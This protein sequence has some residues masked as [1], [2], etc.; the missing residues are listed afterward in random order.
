[1]IFYII[2]YH[3]VLF[4]TKTRNFRLRDSVIESQTLR[5]TP[6]WIVTSQK[7]NVSHTVGTGGMLSSVTKPMHLRKEEVRECMSHEHKHCDYKCMTVLVYLWFY[8]S[9]NCHCAKTQ[10]IS[11]CP[12]LSLMLLT[13]LSPGMQRRFGLI[14]LMLFLRQKYIQVSPCWPWF[15][16]RYYCE[17]YL[18]YWGSC[19]HN[20]YFKNHDY[21]MW[22]LQS[23]TF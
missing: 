18:S 8:I 17:I 14:H 3:H 15:H 21:Y 2:I 6:C 20:H 13:R 7:E 16:L 22:Y 10:K 19:W 11:Q 12:P 5:L 1:M 4:N 9:Q 23:F